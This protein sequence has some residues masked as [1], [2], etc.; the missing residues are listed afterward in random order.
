MCQYQAC[1]HEGR[2]ISKILLV[3]GSSDGGGVM[4][5]GE[6]ELQLAFVNDQRGRMTIERVLPDVRFGEVD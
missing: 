1:T 2:L 5:T 3:R 4:W 6:E